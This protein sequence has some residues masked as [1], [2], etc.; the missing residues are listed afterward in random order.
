MLGGHSRTLA[1][2]RKVGLESRDG[3]VD[4][5]AV[6]TRTRTQLELLALTVLA[7]FAAAADSL[8]VLGLIGAVAA[9]V[10]TH[11]RVKRRAAEAS[12]WGAA[13]AVAFLAALGGLGVDHRISYAA[14][15]VAGAVTLLV[16]DHTTSGRQRRSV[17]AR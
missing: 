12:A 11:S 14:P 4:E 16:R 3:A 9:V 8:P 2:P 13:G 7:V 6:A 5:A 17:L 15:A 10:G 1:Q